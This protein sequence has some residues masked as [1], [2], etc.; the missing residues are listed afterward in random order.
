MVNLQTQQKSEVG[1][2]AE[3][4]SEELSIFIVAENNLEDHPAN[5]GLRLLNYESDMECIQDGFR[6]ANLMKN[7]HN[8]CLLY[9][10]PSPRD[11]P[12]SRMPSSA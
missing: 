1:I 11:I 8:I 9:T 12:L 10:S 4:I 2:L 6:L 5:G 7:K 3:Y